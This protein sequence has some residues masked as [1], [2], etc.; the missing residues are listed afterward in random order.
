MKSVAQFEGHEVSADGV[1]SEVV[2]A[3]GESGLLLAVFDEDQLRDLLSKFGTAPNNV[4]D[5]NRLELLYLISNKV[6][7]ERA[8]AALIVGQ[9]ITQHFGMDSEEDNL[10]ILCEDL[11]EFSS[12]FDAVDEGDEE[13]QVTCDSCGDEFDRV[14]RCSCAASYDFD[15]D[16][17]EEQPVIKPKDASEILNV[18]YT[19]SVGRLRDEVV[20]AIIP[21]IYSAEGADIH[22]HTAEQVR[23]WLQQATQRDLTQVLGYI[24][25]PDDPHAGVNIIPQNPNQFSERHMILLQI[26]DELFPQDPDDIQNEP[27]AESVT[28]HQQASQYNQFVS[29]LLSPILLQV[30]SSIDDYTDD[31][32]GLTTAQ[33]VRV[34]LVAA[35]EDELQ[36]VWDTQVQ[37]EMASASDYATL[38]RNQASRREELLRNILTAGTNQDF[39]DQDDDSADDEDFALH[40]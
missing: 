14:G 7:S 28:E 22:L 5:N 4:R 3:F 12:M 2:H 32:F 38:S 10:S 34:W 25:N 26:L 24:Q 18:N 40:S 33:D 35:T 20:L 30:M 11:L 36:G 13:D 27:V 8:E 17:E 31:V 19:N 29:Q 1:L 16:Q 39:N 6:A 23:L 15:E 37:N 9:Y 21:H